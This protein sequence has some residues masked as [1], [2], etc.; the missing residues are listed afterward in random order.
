MSNRKSFERAALPMAQRP[1]QAS[2]RLRSQVQGHALLMTSD[3]SGRAE[4]WAFRSHHNSGRT[5]NWIIRRTTPKR[6]SVLECIPLRMKAGDSGI[7]TERQQTSYLSLRQAIR[8]VFI[9]IAPSWG[10]CQSGE[11][12][13][14]RK[15]EAI[16][17]FNEVNDCN[18]RVDCM[19]WNGYF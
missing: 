15:L 3:H 2:V 12:T 19:N 17:W 13:S 1:H 10:A 16:Y 5:R 11:R 18:D 4:E 14:D 9:N 6:R 8:S 7:L